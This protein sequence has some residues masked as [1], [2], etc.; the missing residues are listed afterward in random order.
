VIEVDGRHGIV[1][2]CVEGVTM[3]RH[4]LQRP[5]TV[6][7]FGD[8]LAGLHLALHGRFAP[9]L[10]PAKDR[11]RRIIEGAPELPQDLRNPALRASGTIAGRRS[12]PAR[13]LPS[14]QRHADGK[15]SSH[16]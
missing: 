11:M 12:S 14:R 16:Y 8:L 2:E 9:E 6:R 3:L 5:W 10:T 15:G 1:F 13:R 7:R 4:I